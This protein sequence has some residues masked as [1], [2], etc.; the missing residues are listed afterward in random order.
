MGRGAR[1]DEP[2]RNVSLHYCS[3]TMRGL[4][5][6]IKCFRLSQLQPRREFTAFG[7]AVNIVPS[8]TDD[9]LSISVIR[10]STEKPII[11]V[12]TRYSSGIDCRR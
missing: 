5:I 7:I 6:Y 1:F 10:L 12:D 8:A 4:C 3:Q 11:I 9:G 2:S